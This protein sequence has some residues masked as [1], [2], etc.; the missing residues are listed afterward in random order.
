[1]KPPDLTV[2]DN[3]GVHPWSG[4]TEPLKTAATQIMSPGRRPAR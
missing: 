2:I 4:T 1:M 3:A